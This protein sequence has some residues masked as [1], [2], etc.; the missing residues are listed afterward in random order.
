MLP[1]RQEA[2]FPF[3]AKQ[4]TKCNKD[5]GQAHG[6]SCEHEGPEAKRNRRA[7]RSGLLPLQPE[8]QPEDAGITQVLRRIGYFKTSMH[9]FATVQVALPP[10]R[11]LRLIRRRR[12]A[13]MHHGPVSKPRHNINQVQSGRY[14]SQTGAMV[15][16][17]FG[18]DTCSHSSRAGPSP[19]QK[20]R[21]AWCD[22][23]CTFHQS[24]NI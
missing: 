7:P 20:A 12:E 9:N 14:K 22:P 23:A 6:I 8:P 5:T 1:Q 2:G 10:E 15:Y 4:N 19:G 21:K 16:A 24:S 18:W 17:R 13:A 11:L 3:A